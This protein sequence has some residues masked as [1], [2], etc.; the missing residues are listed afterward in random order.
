MREG[1][2]STREIYVCDWCDSEIGDISEAHE[3]MIVAKF[4]FGVNAHR[5]LGAY[6]SC[7]YCC[8]KCFI[9]GRDN[10]LSKNPSVRIE[11]ASPKQ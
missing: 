9:S 10:I 6:N 7:H 3:S 5:T 11:W 4:D 8:K 1:T 2:L